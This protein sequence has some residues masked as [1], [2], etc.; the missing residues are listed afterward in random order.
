MFAVPEINERSEKLLRNA[1]A[2]FWE[3]HF[4][5]PFPC[6]DRRPSL[7]SISEKALTTTNILSPEFSSPHS[8]MDALV[9]RNA[10]DSRTKISLK[11]QQKA[12]ISKLSHSS[13]QGV[14]FEKSSQQLKEVEHTTTVE[15]RPTALVPPLNNSMSDKSSTNL[16]VSKLRQR[17]IKSVSCDN[18]EDEGG[19][20]EVNHKL[21]EIRR[22]ASHDSYERSR[23]RRAQTAMRSKWRLPA[24]HQQEQEAE[25]RAAMLKT[26]QQRA[27]DA[28]ARADILH[29]RR[30]GVVEDFDN[31]AGGFSA[32]SGEG[33]SSSSISTRSGSFRSSVNSARGLSRCPTP[34]CSSRHSKQRLPDLRDFEPTA[35]LND[36]IA[37]SQALQDAIAANQLLPSFARNTVS[38]L[39]QRM[40][41]SDLT[42]QDS[43][44][45]LEKAKGAARKQQ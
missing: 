2:V 12:T 6:E 30:E 44:A 5:T 43:L 39:I 45:A 41:R 13:K 4:K 37:S 9:S 34:A 28:I 24:L 16:E 31:C 3:S 27:V 26:T 35:S 38:S 32:K 18:D 15:A 19:G 29:G 40:R 17:I 25:M 14:S 36:I 10:S 8:P 7:P 21:D 22:A 1:A 11:A 42:L 23:H 20:S 33:R